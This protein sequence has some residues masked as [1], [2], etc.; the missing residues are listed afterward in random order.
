MRH[1]FV[2]TFHTLRG[3]AGRSSCLPSNADS[4]GHR[5]TELAAHEEPVVE[6]KPQPW[7]SSA[8]SLAMLAASDSNASPWQQ[9]RLD[10]IV[11]ARHAAQLRNLEHSGGSPSKGKVWDSSHHVRYLAIDRTVF[12]KL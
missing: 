7:Q 3:A 12:A 4:A 8:R 10:R 11:A 1:D 9:Q 6:T 5:E 2:Q